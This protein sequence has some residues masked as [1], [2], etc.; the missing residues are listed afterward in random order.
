MGDAPDAG[1]EQRLAIVDAPGSCALEPG[2]CGA[3]GVQ[4]AEMLRE[5]RERRQAPEQD[6]FGV[7]HGRPVRAQERE[8][9]A[10]GDREPAR[11]D[12]VKVLV[13]GTGLHGRDLLHARHPA[14]ATFDQLGTRRTERGG[15]QD[16][17]ETS[18]A[19]LR[20]L[21][22]PALE[23]RLLARGA[24]V[25]ALEDLRP[26][27]P[28]PHLPEV[29]HHGPRARRAAL[30]PG[31]DERRATIATSGAELARVGLVWFRPHADDVD[32][33]VE[34]ERRVRHALPLPTGAAVC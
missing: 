6:R 26:V 18:R 34:V 24:G 31:A 9:A 30:L 8:A 1:Y 20:R 11:G 21:L 3:I 25:L 32:E 27:I 29:H 33:L 22:P 13:R 17:V 16:A 7:T 28:A 5:G 12:G 2:A 23:R 4:R 15:L 14:H 10:F 19:V